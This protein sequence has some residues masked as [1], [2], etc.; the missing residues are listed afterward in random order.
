VLPVSSDNDGFESGF[1]VGPDITRRK[2]LTYGAQFGA[3]AAVGGLVS[4]CGSSSSGTKAAST[5]L[6]QGL[7][8]LPGGTPQRGGTLTVGVVSG[9]SEENVFPGSTAINADFCRSYQ[10]FNL[11]F[12]CG[13]EIDPIVP[14]LALSA[15]PNAD[16]TVWTFHLRDGVTWHDGKPFTA[17]DVVWNFRSVWS[18]PENFANGFL[19]GLADFKSVRKRDRLTVEVPLLQPVPEFPTILTFQQMLVVQNGAT[20]KTVERSPIGTG[21]FKYVSFTP[22]SESVFAANK[23]YWETGKPY[24]DQLVIKSS[25]TDETALVNALLSGDIDLLPSAP[26]VTAREQLASQQIQVLESPALGQCLGFVMR[27][28]KGPFA[29]N[30][31]RLGFKLLIDR[32]EMINSALAGFGSP[33][34]DI[35]GAGCKYYASDLKRVQDVDQAKSLFKAA[36]VA[37]QTFTLQTTA[38]FAG[39]VESAT[40]LAEQAAA[41]GV[42]V[43]VQTVSASTYFTPAAGYLSR[44]FGQEVNE[45]AASLAESYRGELIKNAPFDDTHWC[46][47]PD[48]NARNA[49]IQRAIQESNPEKANEL[50]RAAQMQQYDE[51]G[52]L[53]WTNLPY[54]DAAAKKVRGLGTGAA[55]NFNSWRFCDGWLA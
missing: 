15:E 14:G 52:Y 35:Q 29:D 13:H 49:V 10:L 48:A 51:G 21:P 7:K 26:L 11:L 27:T 40:I 44:S 33:A 19:A 2:L 17:D 43:A 23:D 9:G 24:V 46:D 39:L 32:Q 30:R 6:R 31:V 47:G 8:A 37:G 20:Q 4:A 34:F 28:D 36:G 55:F 53:W 45:P 16:A 1:E 25:F 42:K 12:Y 38:A 3:A 18:N 22:G 41:A 5:T 50:W 54:V